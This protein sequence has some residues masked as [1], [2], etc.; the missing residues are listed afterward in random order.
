MDA[1]GNGTHLQG[2]VSLTYSDIKEAFGEGFSD[3]EKVTQEWVF[4][5]D[6]GA[7]FT[8]YDWKN[9]STPTC[10]YRWHIG[11]HSD[12]E[13]EKFIAWITKTVRG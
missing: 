4:E 2:H 11:G 8:L 5:S 6:T 1:D 12:K 10:E 3:G 9:D 13:L 7:V